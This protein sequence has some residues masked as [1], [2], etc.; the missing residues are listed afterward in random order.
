M[1]EML[2]GSDCLPLEAMERPTVNLLWAQKDTELRLIT[3][4]VLDHVSEEI[5]IPNSLKE[6]EHIEK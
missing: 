5:L 1:G 6:P 3:Q 2:S 4:S